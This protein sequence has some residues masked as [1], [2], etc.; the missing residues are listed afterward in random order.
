[1]LQSGPAA[2]VI[3]AVRAGSALRDPNIITLDMGGTSTDVAL[4]TDGAIG[5]ATEKE[6][7]G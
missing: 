2:G 5:V 4:I 3:S 1:M 6:V 7:D